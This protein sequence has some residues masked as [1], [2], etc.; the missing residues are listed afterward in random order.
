MSEEKT[1]GNYQRRKEKER[2]TE[3]RKE[4]KTEEMKPQ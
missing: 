3:K 4:R 1:E 2:I